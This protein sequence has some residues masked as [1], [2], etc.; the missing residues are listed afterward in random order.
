MC[1]ASQRKSLAGLDNV[2]AEGSDAFDTLSGILQKLESIEPERKDELKQ[3]HHDLIN[4]KRYLK[5]EY[6]SHCKNLTSD[7][8][9]HCRGFGLSDPKE[10]SFFQ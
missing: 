3:L 6:K 7:I 8:A 2:A 1:P 10:K 9:D 5:G 4:G